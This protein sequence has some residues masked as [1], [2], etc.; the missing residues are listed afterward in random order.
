[1]ARDVMIDLSGLAD[2]VPYEGLGSS[3][4][5]DK[6]G[7]Y[8]FSIT[9][10]NPSLSKDGAKDMLVGVFTSMDED[11]KGKQIIHNV[12]CSGVDSNGKP[13]VRQLG[14][15]LI[16]VG[17]TVE[18]VRSLAAG[19]KVKPDQLVPALTG[20]T[21]FGAIEAENYEGALTSRIK[22]FIP[23]QRYTD[24][25]SANAHRKAH[26]A[27]A[28][29]SGGVGNTAALPNIGGPTTGLAP[30][31]GG[32]PAPMAVPALGI[33]GNSAVAAPNPTARLAGLG[34]PGIS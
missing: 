2:F 15:L 10:L 8:K 14:E 23:Q 6:D 19:G 32:M 30:V 3:D 13:L 34:L 31:G 27:Q 25:V 11:S 18:Q 20:K 9:K 21:C 4:L 26:K 33:P 22:S 1:M 5:F 16:S 17:Y 12:L 7:S 24:A 29:V 28:S